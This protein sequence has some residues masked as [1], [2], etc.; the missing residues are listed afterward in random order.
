MMTRRIKQLAYINALTPRIIKIHKLVL[1]SLDPTN[2]SN[3]RMWIASQAYR[4]S[5]DTFTSSL[6]TALFVTTPLYS[7]T[8]GKILA[9]TEFLDAIKSSK[10]TPIPLQ[11]LFEQNRYV[12]VMA[13]FDLHINNLEDIYENYI[14]HGTIARLKE[15]VIT[16]IEFSSCDPEFELELDLAT[17]FVMTPLYQTIEILESQNDDDYIRSLFTPDGAFDK[18]EQTPGDLGN[19]A[20]DRFLLQLAKCYE[21]DIALFDYLVLCQSNTGLTLIFS[22]LPIHNTQLKIL[23]ST[24]NGILKTINDIL[25]SRDK[26]YDHAFNFDIITQSALKHLDTKV[27]HASSSSLTIR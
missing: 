14:L 21:N 24:V 7:Q 16:P 19:K 26:D 2:H 6:E 17:S 12:N 5:F 20:R 22:L 4:K 27:V 23:F 15:M 3:F 13:V 11:T 8:K 18:I 25:K 1:A 9:S 10:K